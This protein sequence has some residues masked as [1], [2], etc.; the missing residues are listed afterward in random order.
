MSIDVSDAQLANASFS[1]HESVE[2]DSNVTAASVWHPW[3]QSW[4]SFLTAEGMQ[5]DESAVHHTKA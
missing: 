5:T 4:Q 3:K 2:P 1:M